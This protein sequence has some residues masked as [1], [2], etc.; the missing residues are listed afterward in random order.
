[1][2]KLTGSLTALAGSFGA[3]PVFAQN[4]GE[5]INSGLNF[6]TLVGWGTQDLKT[7]IFLVINVIM[8]FLGIVAVVIILWGG[9]QWMTG[10]RCRVEL[11]VFRRNT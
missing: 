10:P 7:V 8:G 6:G 2:K 9:F 5:T 1:M 11:T 3:L 4:L